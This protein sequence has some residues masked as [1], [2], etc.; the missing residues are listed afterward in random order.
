MSPLQVLVLDDDDFM[1]ELVTEQLEQIGGVEVVSVSDAWSALAF[2][3]DE[4]AR[5]DLL[6]FDLG[7]RDLHGTEVM[8]MLADRHYAGGV[9]IISGS[10]QHVLDAAAD[11]AV[12][13]GLRLVDT[14]AKPLDPTRLR[15][16]VER[17]QTQE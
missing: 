9:V 17:V 10:P 6:V 12:G 8:R 14:I 11:I 13:Y 16:A 7:L 3:D 4:V 1:L 2:V 15:S 5:P